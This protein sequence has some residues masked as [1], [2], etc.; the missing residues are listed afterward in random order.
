M[1]CW[2]EK[3]KKKR[4]KK[5]FAKHGKMPKVVKVHPAITEHL[6]LVKGWEVKGDI[7][8]NLYVPRVLYIEDKHKDKVSL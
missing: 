3:K 7:S 2:L 8:P 6:T 4:Q 1:F 5:K